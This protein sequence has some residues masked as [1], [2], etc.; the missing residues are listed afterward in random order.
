M[1][2]GGAAGCARRAATARR[3]AGR[4]ARE[5]GGEKRARGRVRDR[6]ARGQGG[7][8]GGEGRAGAEWKWHAKMTAQMNAK[9]AS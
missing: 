5:I 3:V 8:V 6:E 4:P 9:K 2:R 7:P 1:A